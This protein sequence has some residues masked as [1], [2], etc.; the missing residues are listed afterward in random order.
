MVHFYGRVLNIY[1]I[2]DSDINLHIIDPFE[3]EGIRLLGQL[4]KCSW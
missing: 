2:V 3:T 1:Y 4:S